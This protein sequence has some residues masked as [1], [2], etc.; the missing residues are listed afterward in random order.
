M[1]NSTQLTP[2][3]EALEYLLA[4]VSITQQIE[5]VP[6]YAA[7]GRILAQGQ[8]SKIN[9]P[10]WANSAMDGYAVRFS[11]LQS[12]KP[13]HIS[14]RIP[15]GALGTSLESN[16]AARI[17]TGAPIPEG[18][19]TVIMQEQCSVTD[20]RV[21]LPTAADG[22]QQG[23][24][25]RGQG[26]DVVAGQQVLAAGKRLRAQELGLLASVGV[27]TVP[28]YKKLK[29]A[30]LSTGDELIEPGTL[31]TPGKIYNSNRYTLEALIEALDMEC[32]A[33]GIVADSRDA[34]EAALR[35]GAAQADIV[36]S[37]GGVSVGE[38]DHVKAVI[39]QWGFLHLWKLA[40]KPGKPFAYGE[41]D[42]TPVLGLPGNPSAVLVTFL[43]LARPY[44]LKKQGAS[45]IPTSAMI[46]TADFDV[47]K[48]SIRRHYLHSRLEFP[49]QQSNAANLELPKAQLY[50]NQSSGMLSGSSWADGLTV[51]EIDE[52]VN[53]GDR[54]MFYR[55]SDLLA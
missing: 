44:L 49:P 28:V 48:K 31:P 42:G 24:N 13:L 12:N 4:Q 43:I 50:T 26:E 30:V 39:E 45:T 17:F 10:P 22:V 21:A 47:T 11:D 53:R 20:G 41:F 37:S 2:V 14:Q 7:K 6:L 52:T 38:E 1:N 34:T 3:D 23:Q 16:T 46:A 9:V 55:F 33:L 8:T 35:K 27:A 40:I 32:I 54:V 36:I 18:A 15:A 5:S 29:I 51:I 25:I 19:D